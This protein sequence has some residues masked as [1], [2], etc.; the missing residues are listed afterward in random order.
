[1]NIQALEEAPEGLPSANHI[2]KNV[3]SQ[4]LWK[5]PLKAC[6]RPN[7]FEKMSFFKSSGRGPEGLPSAKP[8]WKKCFFQKPWKRP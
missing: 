3:V 4:K 1:M 6:L 2:W 5:R 7:Q 8:I